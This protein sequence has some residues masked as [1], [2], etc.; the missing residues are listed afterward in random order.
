MDLFLLFSGSV[1]QILG[2]RTSANAVMF[3][4]YSVEVVMLKT[5]FGRAHSCF[6]GLVRSMA[7]SA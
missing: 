2:L 5:K 4:N 6:L 3:V 7:L 1:I